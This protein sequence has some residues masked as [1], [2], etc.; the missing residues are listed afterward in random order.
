MGDEGLMFKGRERMASVVGRWSTT[1]AISRQSIA[2]HSFYVALYTDHMCDML[3]LPDGIRYDA[4]HWALIHDMPETV[5]SDIPGPVK[6]TITNVM[7]LNS[8]E[9]TIFQEL[10][11]P[12][13]APLFDQ[14]RKIVKAANLIDEVFYLHS[15]QLLGN[16]Y[17]DHVA[18][19]SWERMEKALDLAGLPHLK[20]KIW[21]EMLEM[22][23]GVVGLKNDSDLN[24]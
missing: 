4:L 7:N 9:G 12:N 10:E 18:R 11:Y 21:I 3:R 16:K 24:G 8:V 5:T 13:S 17:L 20:D 14:S 1:P 23:G 2:D 6:R 19:N 22:Q 15:E